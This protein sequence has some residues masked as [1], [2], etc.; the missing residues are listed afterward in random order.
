MVNQNLDGD[1]I[2]S[3]PLI[4]D[5]TM[6]LIYVYNPDRPMKEITKQYLKILKESI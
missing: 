2:I 3:V 5:E 4:S 1:N 6:D